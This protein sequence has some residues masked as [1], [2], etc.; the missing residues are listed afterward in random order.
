MPNK[1]QKVQNPITY[2]NKYEMLFVTY[3]SSSRRK[4]GDCQ[5]WQICGE[6]STVIFLVHEI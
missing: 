6:I 4:H 3:H 2:P 5:Y 1:A